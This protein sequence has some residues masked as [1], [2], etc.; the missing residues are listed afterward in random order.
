MGASGILHEDILQKGKAKEKLEVRAKGST[1]KVG[2]KERGT[3][4][5]R[6]A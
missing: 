4:K 5:K 1:E 2:Q 3:G 6:V